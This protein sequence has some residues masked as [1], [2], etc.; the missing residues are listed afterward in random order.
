M[1][2]HKQ[3]PIGL[4]QISPFLAHPGA[5]LGVFDDPPGNSV[6]VEGGIFNGDTYA[7]AVVAPTAPT[8]GSMRIDLIV[9]N[10]LASGGPAIAVIT[11]EEDDPTA[12]DAFTLPGSAPIAEITVRGNSNGKVVILR[13]DILDRRPILSV[14]AS[15][16]Q[17]LFHG[18]LVLGRSMPSVGSQN[19]MGENVLDVLKNDEQSDVY[20][21]PKVLTVKNTRYRT[22][23]SQPP[24]TTHAYMDLEM[25]YYVDDFHLVFTAYD[26]VIRSGAEGAQS[27]FSQKRLNPTSLDSLGRGLPLVRVIGVA[28]GNLFVNERFGAAN[29]VGRRG[30]AYLDF[31]EWGK[32]S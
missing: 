17:M 28:A 4:N 12:P 23:L 18:R 13:T 9:A 5:R 15:A 30:Q 16:Y 29:V 11:G 2:L 8:V 20:P 1:T 10:P 3:R 32:L 31:Q 24:N 19:L 7:G 14:P 6:A 22:A 27:G 21:F 26:T 25:P